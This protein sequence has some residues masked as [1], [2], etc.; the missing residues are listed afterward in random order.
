MIFDNV[1]F[2]DATDYREVARGGILGY[3]G[4]SRSTDM[5]PLDWVFRAYEALRAAEPSRAQLLMD[6]IGEALSALDIRLTSGALDF[7]CTYAAV[8]R[9][10]E[11]L[12]ALFKQREYQLKRAVPDNPSYTVGWLLGRALGPLIMAR[13]AEAID[14]A[15]QEIDAGQLDPMPYLAALATID[16]D[17]VRARRDDLEKRWP[18]AAEII[19]PNLA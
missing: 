7:F 16:P 1:T 13:D 10:R 5:S 11:R 2:D 8:G 15:K 12:L 14:E 19:T 6:A 3:V 4:G 18:S 9:A 17:W